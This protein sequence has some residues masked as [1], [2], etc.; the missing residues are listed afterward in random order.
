V[1]IVFAIGAGPMTNR[2]G[3]QVLLDLKDAF[4]VPFRVDA[5]RIGIH[6]EYN[7]YRWQRVWEVIEGFEDTRI[8]DDVAS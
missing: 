7:P 2:H 6:L 8:V 5:R 4:T 3:K 1:L